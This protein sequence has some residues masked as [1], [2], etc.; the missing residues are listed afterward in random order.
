MEYL[1]LTIGAT[2]TPLLIAYL[3]YVKD[4]YIKNNYKLLLQFF[5]IGCL[6]S[7]PAVIIELLLDKPFLHNNILKWF[8]GVALVE[9]GLKYI[10]LLKFKSSL[11]DI[12]DGIK[13]STIMSMGFAMV[14]NVLYAIKNTETGFEV[15]A[16]RMFTAI[17]G[18]FIYG[19]IMGYILCLGDTKIK[20]KS[21]LV[22]VSLLIPVIIHGGYDYFISNNNF[23]GLFIDLIAFI[24]FYKP[25]NNFINFKLS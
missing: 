8:I 9:E 25:F 6:L 19:L 14:E 15:V 7:I 20:Y 10:V 2:I 22:F 17:P 21:I 12:Y 3:I 16:L 5:I 18:H 4:K 23:L 24:S 11:I 1:Q 13:Y